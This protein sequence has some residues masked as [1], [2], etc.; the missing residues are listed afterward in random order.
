MMTLDSVRT[1]DEEPSVQHSAW[2]YIHY[3]VG[4]AVLWL[5]VHGQQP[6]QGEKQQQL[7]VLYG[8]NSKEC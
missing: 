5:L 3:T 6:Q 2:A 8:S 4:T 1:S 7:K